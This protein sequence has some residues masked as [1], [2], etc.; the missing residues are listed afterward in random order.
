MFLVLVGSK[1]GRPAVRVKES[2]CSSVLVWYGACFFFHK[3]SLQCQLTRSSV[4]ERHSNKQLRLICQCRN[5]KEMK[6]N[7]I[8]IFFFFLVTQSQHVCYLK[9]FFHAFF[10]LFVLESGKCER[11]IF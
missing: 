9:Y 10:C 2:H 7:E 4:I 8:Y 5:S 11:K 1:Q 6:L 3:S